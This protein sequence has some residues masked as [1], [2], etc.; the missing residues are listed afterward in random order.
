[1]H[2]CYIYIYTKSLCCLPSKPAPIEPASVAQSVAP[3]EPAPIEPVS[4]IYSLLLIRSDGSD[5]SFEGDEDDESD[6]SLESDEGQGHHRMSKPRD[7]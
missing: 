6:E 3:I 7:A 1:M 4:S 5:E 2:A